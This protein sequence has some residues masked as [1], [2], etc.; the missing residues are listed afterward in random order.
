MFAVPVGPISPVIVPITEVMI[1]P[2]IIIPVIVPIIV[3]A[4]IRVVPSVMIVLPMIGVAMIASS[5]RSGLTVLTNSNYAGEK[6]ERK[7]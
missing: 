5:L 2:I 3:P 7:N 6:R 1:M 4:M